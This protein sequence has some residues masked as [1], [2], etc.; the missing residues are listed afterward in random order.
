M[1]NQ[2]SKNK[3][4][5][6]GFVDRNLY[7]QVIRLAKKDGMEDNKFGFAQKLIRE[8]LARYKRKSA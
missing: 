3:V 7:E 5:L 6:G 4:R 1:P 2:R 8:A